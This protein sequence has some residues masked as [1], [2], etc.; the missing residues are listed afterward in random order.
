M[1]NVRPEHVK[2]VAR[3]LLR[4]YAD[5]FT[6][7][8]DENKEIIQSVTNI[9]STKLRNRVAGYV[10]RILATQVAQTSQSNEEAE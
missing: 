3:E 6:T 7:N 5:K 1:G 2:R 8:F 9:A 4:R 10:T